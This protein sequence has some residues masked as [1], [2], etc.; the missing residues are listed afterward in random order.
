VS[1]T[2]RART[3]TPEPLLW[4][5]TLGALAGF[6]SVAATV[7]ALQ[8]VTGVFTP[9]VEDLEAL[10]LHS[11]VLPGVWLG[12]SVGVPCAAVAWLALRRRPRV[13]VAAVCAGV[14]LLVELVVQVPF[15]GFDPLQVVMGV[16]AATML[17]L[18]TLSWRAS[19]SSSG[20]RP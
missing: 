13:G 14:L 7:G 5:R 8:L 10:G 11:W 15:V 3:R 18:G 9:P 1:T 16:V 17:V 20:G 12:L 19:G 6:T 4:R 2:T